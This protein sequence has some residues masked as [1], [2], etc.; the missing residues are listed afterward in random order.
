VNTSETFSGGR[1]LDEVRPGERAKAPPSLIRKPI[2]LPAMERVQ[3]TSPE[4]GR[5]GGSQ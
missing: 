4:S 2:A 5:K 3:T 1:N